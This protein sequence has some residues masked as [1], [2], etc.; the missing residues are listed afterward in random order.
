MIIVNQNKSEIVNF[1]RINYI[2]VSKIDKKSKSVIEINYA[3][4]DW[5]IIAEYK[6]EE[7]AKEILQ[8]ICEFY[9][10]VERYKSSNGMAIVFGKSYVYEMPKE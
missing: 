10:T 7:R 5:K 6:T 2:Q 3:D 1:D 8:D 9:E 4:M